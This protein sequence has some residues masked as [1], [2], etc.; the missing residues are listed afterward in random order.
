MQMLVKMRTCPH[1]KWNLCTG[2]FMSDALP[3][4]ASDS[5]G[6]QAG[7]KRSVSEGA[8]TE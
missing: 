6:C 3:D 2:A 4:V 8:Y 5:H 7:M 1:V